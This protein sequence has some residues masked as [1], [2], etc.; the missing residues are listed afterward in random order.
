[1]IGPHRVSIE[2]LLSFYLRHVSLALGRSATSSPQVNLP[3]AK[4]LFRYKSGLARKLYGC[5]RATLPACVPGLSLE[6]EAETWA[7]IVRLAS[8]VVSCCDQA[9]LPEPGVIPRET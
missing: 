6:G 4:R 8:A 5:D 3:E 1:M 9:E 2:G 7:N